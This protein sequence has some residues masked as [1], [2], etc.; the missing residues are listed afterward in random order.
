MVADYMPIGVK[1]SRSLEQRQE[2][3]RLGAGY[4]RAEGAATPAA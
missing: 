3:H 1:I 4:G 2:P